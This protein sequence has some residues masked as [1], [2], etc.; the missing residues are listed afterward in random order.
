[1]STPGSNL[2]SSVPIT[3]NCLP[4]VPHTPTSSSHN[5]AADF[6]I[7]SVNSSTSITL[8]T[9]PARSLTSVWTGI[10]DMGGPNNIISAFGTSGGGRVHFSSGTYLANSSLSAGAPNGAV[11][12]DIVIAGDGMFFN[13]TAIQ[14]GPA[15]AL[16]P[17]VRLTNAFGITLRDIDLL[18]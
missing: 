12:R 2:C 8:K 13:G 6:Q 16:L 9:S 4:D 7:A 14:T 15:M 5:D 18:G 3:S 1:V 10:D 11:V 17:V